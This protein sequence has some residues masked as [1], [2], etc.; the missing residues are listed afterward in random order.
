MLI[1]M[2]GG[3]GDMLLLTIIT[4]KYLLEYGRPCNLLTLF[5]EIFTHNPSIKKIYTSENL[6][7]KILIFI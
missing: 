1:K 2:N 4:K 5:P 6:I 3:I 7:L